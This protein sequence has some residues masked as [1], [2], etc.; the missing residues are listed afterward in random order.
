[1]DASVLLFR[2]AGDRESFDK[3]GG[4]ALSFCADESLP[5]PFAVQ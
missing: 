5:F 2:D 4:C 3:Q 1:M